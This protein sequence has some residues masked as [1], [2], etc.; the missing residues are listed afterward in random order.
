MAWPSPWS[1][2]LWGQVL[3]RAF[4]CTMQDLTLNGGAG[5]ESLKCIA[6]TL[7]VERRFFSFHFHD[8]RRATAEGLSGPAR[9]S[10]WSQ[11][12]CCTET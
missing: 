8:W 5:L 7:K 6:A 11:C 12:R 10:A 9:L 1:R 2:K 3:H 4:E